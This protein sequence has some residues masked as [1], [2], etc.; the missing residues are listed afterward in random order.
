[1]TSPPNF[2]LPEN[3]PLTETPDKP[4]SGVPIAVA[5][6]GGVDSAVAALLLKRAGARVFAVFMKNWEDDD[7]EAGC[8]DKDDLIAAAAAAD[9]LGVELQT[10]NFAAEY[11]ARVFAPFLRALQNGRTPNPDVLCN[12]E[13]KFEAF[14]RYAQNAGAQIAATGHYARIRVINGAP[15]LLKGEDS[16]KDQSYFLHRLSAAQLSGFIFPLGGHYKADVRAIARAAG[17]GNWS[18][19]DSMGICFVGARRFTDFLQ[20]YISPSPG[21]MQ[22]PEGETVGEHGGLA[23]YTIGQRRGLKIGGGG[24]P[25]FVVGKRRR[26]NILLVAQGEHPMLYSKRVKIENAHWIAGKPPPE[27][28]VFSARLR[29]R[30]P[31]SG[32]ALNQSAETT[33]EI[34]FAEAQR[35]AAPGQYAVL[36]DG[37]ICLGGGEITEAE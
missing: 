37:N 20:R 2:P 28:H 10:A 14:R 18:R 29:H 30:Q 6:S 24:A 25:W 7:T 11:K 26:G 15:C 22:T 12:S 8:H 27:N 13:I 4:L 36:Y 31:P 33:A 34:V 9:A 32:C 1:M 16:A 19:P 17:L 21:A 23:F 35:A 3:F 5:L